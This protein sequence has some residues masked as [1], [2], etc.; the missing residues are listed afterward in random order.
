M[1]TLAI[2]K[3]P[4]LGPLINGTVG[5]KWDWNMSTAERHHR[6]KGGMYE[7]GELGLSPVIRSSATDAK[8]I[9]LPILL[10]RGFVQEYVY[11][12]EETPMTSLRDLMG[13][14]VGV[15]ALNSSVMV[16]MRGVLSD[17][18]GVESRQIEWYSLQIEAGFAES[19]KPLA[20]PSDFPSKGK[21]LA[22]SERLDG[23]SRRVTKQDYYLIHLLEIRALDAIVL[24]VNLCGP[25]IRTVIRPE[26][27]FEDELR[28]ERGVYPAYHVLALRRD[29]VAKN[30]T[31]PQDIVM[32]WKKSFP[33]VEHGLSENARKEW[34]RDRNACG[35]LPPFAAEIR[36]EDRNMFDTYL[37][38]HREQ[39]LVSRTLRTEEFL[40]LE[41]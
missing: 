38:Y 17:F 32:A 27:L 36:N 29:V 20:I 16:W 14:R 4:L 19:V 13:L 7:G 3:R 25:G 41:G 5:L 15:N 8:W 28:K 10:K 9:G 21:D 37:R 39:K 1:I 30:P 12:R 35:G 26:R 33:F 40:W 23:T 31:L 2:Y 34:E 22:A 18:Y 11:C 24:T 6:M